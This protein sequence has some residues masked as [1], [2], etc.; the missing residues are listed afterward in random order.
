MKVKFRRTVIGQVAIAILLF[1]L[2]MLISMQL[3]S[4]R[5]SN[6]AK[7]IEKARA[8]ELALQINQLRQENNA[9]KS[10]IYDLE[11]KIKEYQD[12]ASNISKTTE[13]LQ[14]DLDNTKLLAGLT[15]LEGPGII[16]TLDDSKAPSDPNV[17]PNTF[18]LHDSDILQV[19]NELKAAGAEAISIND[20]RI[21]STT[22]IRCAGPTVSINN[23][24]YSAPYII[25][26]IGDPK[27]LKNSL[28][29][30]GGIVDLLKQFEIQVKIEEAASLEIPRYTGVI[31]F[32]YAKTK[33]V[34]H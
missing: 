23:T 13:I 12:S 1:L 3:K 16:I 6:Q 29:M 5:E 10:Q 30:R 22:E 33:D 24:R 28:N 25:K 26:A 9:L 20:Q 11:K 17:D 7:N 19:I 2:G 15:D 8:I 27:I 32:K 34:G 14:Q 31:K 18:L 4:V 21:I